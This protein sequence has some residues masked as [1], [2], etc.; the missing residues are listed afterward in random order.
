VYANSSEDALD[1]AD[2]DPID[3]GDLGDRHSVIHPGSD[4]RMVRPRDL[5]RGPGLGIDLSSRTNAG[6][7]RLAEERVERRLAAI[8]CADVVGYSRLMGAD[9]EGTLAVIKGHR[10]ELIDPLIHQHRG[11][12]FKTTGDGMLIEFASVVGIP[13]RTAR[14]RR[15]RSFRPWKKALMT[16]RVSWVLDLDIRTFFDSLTTDG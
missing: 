6:S 3:L 10:R 12:I 15:F 14:S 13:S 4:A 1:H 16:Q 7:K 2:G 5:T 8:L 9:E 11:R